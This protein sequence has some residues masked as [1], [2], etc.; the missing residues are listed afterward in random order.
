MFRFQVSWLRTVY[1]I[2]LLVQ[3]ISPVSAPLHKDYTPPT[4]GIFTDSFI[5]PLR[6]C[7]KSKYFKMAKDLA[8]KLY[9]AVMLPL[10]L[11]ILTTI[12]TFLT[13]QEMNISVK[14]GFSELL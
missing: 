6:S 3:S 5:C 13:L 9:V 10:S 7:K 12:L 4:T 2:N 1:Q 14:V 11:V 8:D